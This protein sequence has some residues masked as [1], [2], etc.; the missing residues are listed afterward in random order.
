MDGDHLGETCGKV[1]F[2][3]AFGVGKSCVYREESTEK[4]IILHSLSVLTLREL[5][6]PI[7]KSGHADFRV[8]YHG[9]RVP[10]GMSLK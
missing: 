7:E 10:R 1:V 5:I 3:S 6:R 4:Y 8:G 9:S 2:L